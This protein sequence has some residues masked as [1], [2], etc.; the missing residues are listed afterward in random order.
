MNAEGL[1]V[2]LA[3]GGRPVLG[4]G[5]GVPLIVRY[6]LEVCAD[7][8]D[9]VEALR[10]LPCH[11]AYNLTLLD[12]RGAHATVLLS[13]DRPPIV[14]GAPFATN[15]QLG[16]EWPRHGRLS[17]TLERADFLE[18]ALSDPGLDSVSLLRLFLAPPLHRNGYA[19]GFGTVY[20]AMYRPVEGRM[21]IAWPGL[22]PWHQGFGAFTEGARRIAYP[23]G[24]T[25]REGPAPARRLAAIHR[26]ERRPRPAH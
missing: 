5:F 19:L 6:L 8:P 24:G 10:G 17:Q 16:V 11:M 15:H 14:T 22:T 23:D 9:A 7:V 13:P 3:F 21:K 2:S 18:R 1:V 26:D 4:Q 25:P 20:T 12:R